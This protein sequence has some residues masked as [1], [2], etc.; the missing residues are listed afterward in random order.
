[1]SIHFND[2]F[3]LGKKLEEVGAD[4]LVI[5]NTIKGIRIDINRKQIYI[6]NKYSGLSG[7][8][9]LPIALY[10]IYE[11]Y[12]H[13]SIPIIGSGGVTNGRE[14]IEMMMAGARCVQIGTANFINP[15][16]IPKINSEITHKECS[17][18]VR[19]P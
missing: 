2:L 16:V 12:K 9:I 8:A 4:A 6:K 19:R 11:M 7:N 13:V 17:I 15:Y 3:L 5:M 1:M 10:Y 18:A 14:A